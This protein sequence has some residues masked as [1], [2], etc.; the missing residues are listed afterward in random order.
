MRT[1]ALGLSG[2]LLLIG[3]A[4]RVEDANVDLTDEAE[5]TAESSSALTGTGTAT[6][7]FTSTWDTG[8]CANVTVTNTG[9]NPSNKWHVRLN[10][11]SAKVTA[12]TWGGTMSQYKT[13]LDILPLAGNTS[14]APGATAN[15]VPGFCADRPAG[16][17]LPTVNMVTMNYCGMAYRDGDHDGYGAGS[18]VY[19]C[20]AF[21]YSTKSGDC[22]DTDF[23]A[24][25][26]QTKY[27]SKATACGGFDYNCNSR[28]GIKSNG[29][30]GCYETPMTCSLSADRTR[31]IASGALPATC[32]GGFTS[33]GTA[34]CGEDWYSSS[35]GCT[36][37]CSGA[38]CWCTAW[39]TGGLGGQQ[40]CN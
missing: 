34:S 31:C 13:S 7:T 2:A 4:S 27:F 28:T 30:Q 36:R 3:C 19:T 15:P 11:F 39:H 9:A 40:A 10:L 8:Y 35:K 5:A 26:G 38:S 25:P 23:N 33:Y 20:D 22:C 12:N 17:P 1:Y 14:I 24:F 16:T 21:G 32:N 6:L 29:P 37:A 18:E